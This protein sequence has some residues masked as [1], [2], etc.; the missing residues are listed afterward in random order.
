[1]FVRELF[2]ALEDKVAV[3]LTPVAFMAPI[4]VLPEELPLFCAALN[5]SSASLTRLF[6]SS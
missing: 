5:C 2:V 6:K 3:T 1:M 4:F